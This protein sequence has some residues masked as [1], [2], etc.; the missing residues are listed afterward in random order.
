ME[1]REITPEADKGLAEVIRF[2][3]EKFGLD[4][5]GTA[6]FDPELDHMS[7]HYL[8]KPE[9]R[10]YFIL[11]DEDKVCGGIGFDEFEHIEDCAEI[12]KLYLCDELKGK[13]LGKKLLQVAEDEVIKMGYKRLY[14]ETHTNLDIAIKMYKKYGYEE[15]DKPSFVSHGAMNCFLVKEL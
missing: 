11:W 10:K 14:I 4:I 15:I 2:N 12:Q 6:Y 13:G 7:K 8:E 9:K 5:P 3:F 1:I